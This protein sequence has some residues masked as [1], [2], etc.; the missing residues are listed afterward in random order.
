M[1]ALR[2]YTLHIQAFSNSDI[3]YI[4][5]NQPSLLHLSSH[6]RK[7]DLKEHT[8][9]LSFLCRPLVAVS[10]KHGKLMGFLRAFMK[11]R[12]SKQKLKQ[13]GILKE[14]VFGCDLGEHLLN[15]GLDGNKTHRLQ[16][17]LSTLLRLLYSDPFLFDILVPEVLKSCSE[18]IEKHGIVDGIY[19]HSGISSNIQKL[20][21]V[22]QKWTA[23]PTR[24]CLIYTAVQFVSKLLK[25]YTCGVCLFFAYNV[26]WYI[27]CKKKKLYFIKMSTKCFYFGYF[28]TWPW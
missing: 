28:I 15:S 19:R 1:S 26:L 14:R 25:L 17:R 11:S 24:E 3:V 21:F 20:R 18:F 8:F 2:I 5:F 9:V 27:C 23:G 6:S 13:R 22:Y 10:K 16:I 12:P 7:L 4:F